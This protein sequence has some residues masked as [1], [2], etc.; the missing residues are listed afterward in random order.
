MWSIELT[1]SL[2]AITAVGFL[3]SNAIQLHAL[4]KRVIGSVIFL[5][6][7]AIPII[8]Q[9]G[10]ILEIT[11]L[12]FRI[13]WSTI[14]LISGITV[15]VAIVDYFKAGD[16]ENIENYPPIR[17]SVWPTMLLLKSIL[18]WTMFLFCYE[19]IFR[20]VFLFSAIEKFGLMEAVLLNTLV[21]SLVHLLKSK[22][23]A[24]MSIPMALLLCYIAWASGSFWYA[25]ML[26]I[27]LA[28]VHEICSISSNPKMRFDFRVQKNNF[29][30]K[31]IRIHNK[32]ES[33][34]T[35][36]GY[37]DEEVIETFALVTGASS[38]IGRAIAE[39]LAK[40]KIN[41]ILVALPNTGLEV[42]EAALVREYNIR[43]HTFC[44]DLT[45]PEAPLFLVN[46]CKEKCIDIS[47]LVNN[48]GFG[49][50]ELFED[51]DLHELL[52]MMALNNRAL[53]SITH[54]FTPLLKGSGEAY[55]LNVGSLASVFKIPYKAV[56]SATKS[57]VYSFSAALRL[58]LESS[59]ISVSCLCPGSTLTSPRVRDILLRTAGK[60]TLFV[61]TPEV[62]AKTAVKKL[63]KG[64]FKIVPGFL[65]RLLLGVSSILPESITN[66]LLMRLFKPKP[67]TTQLIVSGRK[68]F[69][70]WGL[71]SLANR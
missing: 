48:A 17:E 68:N 67:V 70:G 6:A 16:K 59:N 3:Q 29:L 35:L 45:Q 24:L 5:I 15:L 52:Q 58:E 66:K 64:Q 54:L 63:F 43:T 44:L 10:D 7:L 51:S 27:A 21:C 57:F 28:I 4:S 36:Y 71:L 13:D 34:N 2:V 20:G 38:G 62:V 26:H 11:G 33:P 46:A 18:T 55:I 47:I 32:K 49:N 69:E 37:S 41:L 22:R 60:N 50:L 39:E 25:A 19:M 8:A 61:Q 31:K 14:V 65:N 30:K 9:P 40:Q 42:V 56:Y 1:T 53:V 12:G 23:E